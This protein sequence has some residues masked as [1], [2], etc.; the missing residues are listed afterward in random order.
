MRN[1]LALAA[2]ALLAFVVVGYFLD[3]YHIASKP[4]TT[5]QDYEVQVNSPKISEDLNKGKEKLRKILN[6][7]ESNTTPTPT[8]AHQTVVPAGVPAS[9]PAPSSD[10]TV[11]LPGSSANPAH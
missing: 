6:K 8:P 7:N 3:W 5:G 2:A 1:L 10:G 11:V 4:T 9:F